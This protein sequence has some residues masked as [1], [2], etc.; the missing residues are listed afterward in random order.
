MLVT[1]A[2]N[3]A[4]ITEAVQ[5]AQHEQR[6]VCKICSLEESLFHFVSKF[7]GSLISFELFQYDE[8]LLI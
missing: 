2:N 7:D 6:Q 1:Y 8:W 4:V 3:K 5:N